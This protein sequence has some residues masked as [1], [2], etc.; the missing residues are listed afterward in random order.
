MK[1]KYDKQ[2]LFEVMG[3]LDKTF[4]PTLNESLYDQQGSP[5]SKQI[6]DILMRDT[7]K[8]MNVNLLKL[9]KPE[10]DQLLQQHPEFERNQW[11]MKYT[12]KARSQTNP[13]L[14]ENIFDRFTMEVNRPDYKGTIKRDRTGWMLYDVTDSPEEAGPFGDLKSLM[15]YYD[16]DKTQVSGNY[17]RHL[18]E[19]ANL[20]E[21][22]NLGELNIDKI[23]NSYIETAIWAE[24]S[25]ENDLQGKTINDVDKESVANSKIEI[26]NFIKKAQ[27][28]ASDELSAYDSETLGHNLWLSRNGHGA[29]FFDDNNDK[30]QNLARSMKPV[31]IYLGDD[32]KIYIS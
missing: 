25:D 27:Q 20:H 31:D 13:T 14:N 16:I 30:L 17:V 4:K 9:E 1:S 6:A 32:G 28:E 3:K 22:V 10:I 7:T 29:G 19:D 12:E 15:D 21:D 11:F 18:R 5:E 23:L 2:R 26:Y 24:E 8:V